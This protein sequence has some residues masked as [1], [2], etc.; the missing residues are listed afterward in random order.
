MRIGF[1][2]IYSWRPHVEHLHFLARL[3]REDGHHTEFLTCDAELP[4]CYT[5]ELRDKRPDW[6]ECLMCRIGGIRSYESRHVTS[7][8]QYSDPKSH[9]SNASREWAYSS[10]STLGRFET[11]GD[12]SGPEF[13]A[14]VAKLQPS[15]EKTYQAALAWIEDKRLDALAIFNGRIDNTRAILE[16]ARHKGIPFVSV[17]RT[18]FGDGLQILPDEN[19][20]GLRSVNQLVADWSDKAL[21]G[22]QARKA[23]SFIASRFLSQNYKEWR[24]YNSNAQVKPWPA[25]GGRH[26]F[27]LIPGSLNEQWGH[28]D[29]SSQWPHP[30][31]AYNA[32]IEHFGL[33]ASDLVL[34]CHPNWGEK[35]GK[36]DGHLSEEFY[37]SWARERGIHAIPS[38]DRTSTIGLIDECEVMVIGAG[39]SGLEAGALGKQMIGIS[40]SIYQHASMR[41]NAYSQE[42]VCRLKLRSE[43]SA[44]EQ[45]AAENSVRRQALRFAYTITYRY[46]QYVD[47]VRC[48]EPTRFVYKAGADP[49]RFIEILK[50]NELEPDDAEFASSP[51]AEDFV[52]QSMKNSRW[53]EFVAEPV[54]STELMG[55]ARRRPFGLVDSIRHRM[56]RGDR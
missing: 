30:V 6:Q 38:Q 37:L 52:L 1:A 16:A 25:R 39:S 55:I 19:C 50:N 43:M 3:A 23:A 48:I 42:Q 31:D 35:I 9:S 15:I 11:S 49:R 56:Q 32:I 54:P 24:A 53:N 10:A 40:P 36:N 21:T 8:G 27:L 45:F 13:G 41:D 26:K 47:Y 28:P 18:W 14:I 5:R 20:L 17:E 46:A 7:I 34:R 33:E 29:W 12:Y 22:P 4:S 51:D 44:I 2:S